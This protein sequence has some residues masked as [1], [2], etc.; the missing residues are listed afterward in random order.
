MKARRL[1]H[2]YVIGEPLFITFRLHDSLPSHRAFQ[3]GNL[4]SG[5][6]F[7]AMDRLLDRARTGPAFL[8]QPAIARKVVASLQYGVEIGHYQMHSWVIMPNHVHLLLTP[9]VSVPKLLGSL[10]TATA[11]RANLILG[12]TGGTFWQA[13]SYDHRVRTEGE[14]RRIKRY[15][16]INPVAACL[17][18][19]PEEYP[20][21]SAFPAPASG[22]GSP[23]QTESPPH[24][25]TSLPH[26]NVQTPG[27]CF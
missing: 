8:R 27:A 14:F 25:D 15:I 20:W 19:N 26:Q 17:A 18:A 7:V 16:E 2:L 24:Q 3:A 10:K 1:P 23:A 22:A 12:R 5:K 11:K 21:S 13:E 4:T 6:A 9:N